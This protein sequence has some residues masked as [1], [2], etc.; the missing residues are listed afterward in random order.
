MKST[1][2]ELNLDHSLCAVFYWIV[3]TCINQNRAKVSF[4]LLT[5]NSNSYNILFV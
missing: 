5:K 3:S 4:I 2:Q 1:T